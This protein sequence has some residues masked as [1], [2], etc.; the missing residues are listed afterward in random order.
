MSDEIVKMDFR[1][2]R[3]LRDELLAAARRRFPAGPSD[4]RGRNQGLSE[5]LREAVELW[6]E[7]ERGGAYGLNDRQ[8]ALLDLERRLLRADGPLLDA[9][10]TLGAAVLER[11][12]LAKF[13]R[14]LGTA[15]TDEDRGVAESGNASPAG[16]RKKASPR[17]RA[18]RG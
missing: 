15:L 5:I 3:S 12:D 18:G 9:W 4:G 14:A 6:L 16:R 13:L 1:G 7:W 8:Q 17:Q 10:M 2:P 11:E